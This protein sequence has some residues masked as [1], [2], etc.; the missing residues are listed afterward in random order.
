MPPTSDEEL[1][2]LQENVEGLRTQ[3]ADANAE[4][5]AYERSLSN[6]VTAVQLKTEAARL[7]AELTTIQTATERS[8]QD[9]LG[10]SVPI[11]QAEA[12]MEAALAQ[13]NAAEDAADAAVQARNDAA[14]EAA[15]EAS[16]TDVSTPPAPV[17][18][19]GGTTSFSSSSAPVS[20]TS[21][22]TATSG[23]PSTGTPS[24]GSEA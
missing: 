20:V 13:Q 6:D 16:A 1:L 7:E 9:G 21:T 5:E 2:Q 15:K 8:Q 3:V 17:T 10:A 4:R 19:T 23:T 12:L 24:T 18:T 22:G 14:L 11:V